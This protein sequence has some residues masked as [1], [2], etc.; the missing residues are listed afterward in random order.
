M[1]NLFVDANVVI[2]FL[3]NRHPFSED[4]AALFELA[5]QS[6]VSIHISS[7]SYN[8]FYNILRQKFGHKTTLKY[9]GELASFTSITDV[10]QE[11]VKGALNSG[12][13]DFEGAIQYYS[14]VSNPAIEMIISRDRKGFRNSI[15]P[16]FTPREALQVI[17]IK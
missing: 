17:S 4:A 10:N 8:V 7:V 3:I 2:D 5:E 16:V 13:T 12:N 1:K 9:L 14:A 11:V 15:L 6:V